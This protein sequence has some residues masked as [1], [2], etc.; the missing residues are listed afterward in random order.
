M[1]GLVRDR[2][3]NMAQSNLKNITMKTSVKEV[4]ESDNWIITK[5]LQGLNNKVRIDAKRR[6]NKADQPNFF[7]EWVSLK[8][9]NQLARENYGKNVNDFNCFQY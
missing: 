4:F 8:Y 3:P 2:Y 7:S 6:F 1:Y 9:A 5:I